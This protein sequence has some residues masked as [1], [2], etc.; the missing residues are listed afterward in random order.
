MKPTLKE[1]RDSWEI[2]E[3]CCLSSILEVSASPKPGNMHRF[4]QPG[5]YGASFEQFMAAIAAISPVYYQVAEVAMKTGTESFTMN[6]IHL[7]FHFKDA[8]IRMLQ[9][10]SGGNLLLGH[11]LLLVPLAAGTGYMRGSGWNASKPANIVELGAVSR[12]IIQEGTTADVIA[13][14]E[15]M[16]EVQPG[17]LGKV[18]KLDIN[19]KHFRKELHEREAT[20]I[21]VFAPSA[22]MDLVS[23][24]LTGGFR[25]TTKETFPLI[26]ES[27]THGLDV[28]DAIVHSFVGLLSRHPDSLIWRKNG[29][30]RAMEVSSKA[31]EA[32][33]EG[34]MRTNLG[35][36]K[37]KDLDL[38][39]ASTKGK[40]NPGTTADLIAA[41]I[42]MLLSTGF[43]P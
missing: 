43:I 31:R 13:M 6:H 24:E 23:R 9:S 36:M 38:W 22:H 29:K 33:D 26:Q 20:F 8:M 28:N 37:I 19:S 17:G 2:M 5:T 15:G 40:L 42:F 21:D 3:R 12:N 27:L 18:E 11:I 1:P 16:R 4:T 32:I 30:E 14:Y 41:G 34:G 39:L 25:I 35:R 7:G 10:Q